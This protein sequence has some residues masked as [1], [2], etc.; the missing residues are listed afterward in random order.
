MEYPQYTRPAEWQGRK[1]P[2]VLLSGHHANIVKWQR[3]KALETTLQKRP[4]LLQSAA[5]TPEDQAFLTNLS[6][7]NPPAG[8]PKKE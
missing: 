2:E 5:L 7:A 3:Q 1:V 6:G 8:E 4:E